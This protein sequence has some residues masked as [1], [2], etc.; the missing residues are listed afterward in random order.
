MMAAI[1]THTGI[2]VRASG[3]KR[4]QLHQSATAWIARSN[5][6][7]YRDTGAR[8]GGY[9]RGHIELDSIRPIAPAAAQGGAA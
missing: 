5:E 7:Y 9:G 3:R 1:K 2:V 4:V 6:Y 8:V